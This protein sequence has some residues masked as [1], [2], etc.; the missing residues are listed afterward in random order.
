MLYIYKDYARYSDKMGSRGPKPK[1]TD[2]SCPNDLCVM[3]A[4]C[5]EGNVIANGTYRTCGETIRKYKCKRCGRVFN[6]RT[7]TAYE[8]MHL[9]RDRFDLIAG[10]VSNGVSVRRAAEIARCST[11]TVIRT[12]VRA[13]GHA[14][15]VS[16]EIERDLR[17]DVVE[18]D[19]MTYVL[20]KNRR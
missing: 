13:G 19:E 5:G 16:D 17:P 12:T 7:G 1:Y 20:K 10:C 3:Y 15:K 2:V 11:S 4:V 9:S 6:S 18:F 14:R 8:R